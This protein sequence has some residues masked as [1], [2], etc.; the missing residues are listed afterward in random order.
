MATTIKF[1]ADG[2]PTELEVFSLSFAYTSDANLTNLTEA[3]DFG[4]ITISEM[5]FVIEDPGKDN[6]TKLLAW[7]TSH[8]VKGKAS[9][10]MKKAGADVNPRI[11]ELEHVVLTQYEE[12]VE[13]ESGVTLNLALKARITNIDEVIVDLAI[14]R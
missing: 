8:E 1:K 13:R 6:S 10:S 14:D 9:F 5:A 2:I 12:S 7:I 3:I 4:T 11:I